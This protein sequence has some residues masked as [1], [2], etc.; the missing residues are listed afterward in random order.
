MTLAD[1]IYQ[2]VKPLP[3]PLARE[4]L[5][6]VDFVTRR[7]EGDED[8]NLIQAQSQS[9]AMRDWD[10]EDDEVWNDRPGL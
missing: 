5:D 3:A 7:A 9:E 4:V 10:N 1:R 6:F 2:K 8:R